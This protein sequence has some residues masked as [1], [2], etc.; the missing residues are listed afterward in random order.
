MK[1]RWFVCIL[2]LSLAGASLAPGQF[3]IAVG[4][5]VGGNYNEHTGTELPGKATGVGVII[6]GQANLSFTGSI[7]LL[8]TISFDNRIGK[9]TYSGT[10]G[11]IDYSSD[12]SVTVAYLSIE[13]LFRYTLPNRPFYFV[14]GPSIGFPVQGKS[15]TTTQILTPGYSFSNGYAVQT[16]NTGIEDMKV[17][18]EW[19]I[20]GGY[21]FQIDKKT[22]VSMHLVYSRGFT[23]IVDKLDWRVNSISFLGSFQFTLGK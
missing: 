23:D 16:V 13:P 14:T 11:V 5:A 8:A 21:V 10:D 17:R 9:I 12:A 3:Q 18:F 22:A 15:E 1:I 20:G 6:G 2:T 4:P 19:K 7:G